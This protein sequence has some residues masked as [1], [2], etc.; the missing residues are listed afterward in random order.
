LVVDAEQLLAVSGSKREK[1]LDEQAGVALKLPAKVKEG[2]K[3]ASSLAELCLALGNRL[4]PHT[5]RGLAPG[6]LI[7]QPTAERRRSG[8]HYTPRALTEPIVIEAFRP[9]LERCH[10]QPSAEQILALKVCDPAMGSGAFLVAVCRYLAGWL[11]QAWDNGDPHKA[12]K[13]ST[14]DKDLYARRLIAQSCLYGV[15]K[16]PFAVNLAKLSLWLVTLSQNLPF[17]FVDHALKCGDS[18]VG[19]GVKEIQA[20]MK[21]VQLGFLNEQN[22][23]F[24]QMGVARRESF[25]DDSLNDEGYDRKKVLLQQQIKAT[26]G[27]RQAGDLMV[28]AFFDAPKAKERADKQQVYLAMLCGAFNDEGLQDSIQEIRDR[29]AAGDKGITPFHWDLEFPEVF[30]YG[31]D[32]FDVFVGNPPFVG[33]KRISEIQGDT[34]NSWLAE[35]HSEANKNADLVAHFFRRCFRLLRSKGSLGLIATN[36]I[37]QG[38][39]RSTGLRWICLNGGT[40]YAAR[41]RY[42]WP[43]VAAVVVSVV[44]L[45]KGAYGGAKL[46]ERRPVEQITAFLFA[47]GG[48]DDPKQLAA[49]AGKSFVGSYVL[50]MGFTFDRGEE[51][52]DDTPGIP[53]PIATM[54]RLIAENPKNAE[55]IFPYIGG[56]EVNS[57]PTHSH[58][59]YVINFGERSEEECRLRWPKLMAIL[60]AKVMPERITK[61]GKKYPRMVYEWWKFWNARPAL[62]AAASVCGKVLVTARHQPNWQLAFMPPSSVFS[63]AMVVFTLPYVSVFGG[64]QSTSHELW[65]RFLGSS[66][67]DDLRYT[68]TDCFETF[69]FPTALLDS[70][71]NDPAHESTRQSLE[72]I[73][74]RY[75]QFRAELMVANNEGLTS[76]YNRFHDPAETSP[77]LHELRRL[78]GEM[79]QAVLNAYGWSDVLTQAIA[80]NPHHTPC[81]FGLDYLD[82]EEDAQLP[83]D[84]QERIDGGDLFFWDAGDALDFQGQLQAY[85]AI[86]GRRKLPWRYRWPDAVR[87]D[88]LARLLALN[89]ERY[90]EEVALGLH[91]KGAKQAAKASR[92]V[93]S[94]APGGK[95]RG[96]PAK[97]SQPS[98]TESMQTEQMGLGL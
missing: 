91:S 86:T 77:E 59:R 16:N 54:E 50:G 71:A 15:D 26:E 6:S 79:D 11:V 25:G 13:D 33:G 87:D 30:G 38:D 56:E 83:E 53:S 78:H 84:L 48:H 41:K 82:I 27:L 18:L 68:P 72:T 76:T 35:L 69:P 20:A 2:L 39:T 34:Y 46:L 14:L 75:H 81:G 8:S 60:E 57:S 1:W 89:A 52:D 62:E 47:N 24:A 94:S 63:E 64:L 88:V 5:P 80:D 85:G 29:L 9:W 44:H 36:T 70:A 37:A 97:T 65:A 3:Q 55:V 67:K 42:K 98:E 96:R 45:L 95:R 66:M 43:G 19:Y 73:G 7:L 92:A 49:N 32:G 28:A 4:S 51:A 22:Q 12:P 31:R 58:H 40:I 74:E 93:G 90:E 23:V 61:D 17:T 21:E 10:H